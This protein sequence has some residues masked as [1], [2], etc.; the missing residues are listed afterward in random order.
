MDGPLPQWCDDTCSVCPAQ[1]LGPGR[2][3]VVA[4][5]SQD[6]AYRPEV[7]WRVGPDGTA[8]CVHPYRVGM[9]PGRYASAGTPV[10]STREATRTLPAP[11]A[12]ALKLPEHLDDLEGWLVAVL[13]T[14]A[15]DEIFGAVARAERQAGER[16]AP[17]AVV[18]ALR[19]V[20]SRELARR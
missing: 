8:V 11:T 15:E 4:R 1:E 9:P 5:P 13:R 19:R 7:G 6:F 18:S 3:D 14:A 17:G 20:L 2:F 10:P 12:E 16:F